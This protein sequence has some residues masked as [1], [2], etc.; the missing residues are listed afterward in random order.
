MDSQI[1]IKNSRCSNYNV[2]MS[3]ELKGQCI[4][5][6]GFIVSRSILNSNEQ[7]FELKTYSDKETLIE[8]CFSKLGTY[9]EAYGTLWILLIK[10]P[11]PDIDRFG[12]LNSAKLIQ[13]LNP[14]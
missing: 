14:V 1:S 10:N 8:I 6:S 3:S 4:A 9:N 5:C 13:S 2:H 11:I 7:I 12:N